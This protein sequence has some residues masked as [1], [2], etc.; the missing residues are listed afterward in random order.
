MKLTTVPGEKLTP[1]MFDMPGIVL[2]CIAPDTY[3]L[4]LKPIYPKGF[5]AMAEALW[6]REPLESRMKWKRLISGGN[7]DHEPIWELTIDIYRAVLYLRLVNNEHLHAG[8]PARLP[9]L[10]FDAVHGIPACNYAKL[11]ANTKREL[12]KRIATRRAELKPQSESTRIT[13]P[14]SLPTR[15]SFPSLAILRWGGFA[16]TTYPKPSHPTRKLLEIP[17][18]SHHHYTHH[19]YTHQ[20]QHHPHPHHHHQNQ[21]Q[22]PKRTLH[23]FKPKPFPCSKSP[24]TSR[25]HQSIFPCQ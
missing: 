5:T 16:E 7:P 19:H 3:T 14:A 15:A 9:S 18:P 20:H 8:A 11:P 17:S 10:K 4:R 1:E 24:P 22:H 2:Q 6:R 23:L 12:R 21:P 13:K 25:A